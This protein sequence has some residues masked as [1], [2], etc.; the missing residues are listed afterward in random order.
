MKKPTVKEI[1]EN[2]K[3]TT[4]EQHYCAECGKKTI[5]YA[6]ELYEGNVDDCEKILQNLIRKNVS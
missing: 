6:C 5:L 3:K 1:E 2:G 4:M